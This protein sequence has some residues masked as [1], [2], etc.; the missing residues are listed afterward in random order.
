[1]KSIFERLGWLF[2]GAVCSFILTTC[3]RQGGGDSVGLAPDTLTIV[4]PG[5]T[6]LRD[7]IIYKPRPYYRDTGQARWMPV[8]T[9]AILLDYMT[10]KY[11]VDTL[12]NDTSCLAII[13]EKVWQNNLEH[14]KFRFQ[15]RRQSRVVTITPPPPSMADKISLWFGGTLGRS[16]SEF[17]FGPYVAIDNGRV[18]YGAFYDTYQKD[19]YLT[20]A[21]RLAA[22]KKK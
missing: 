9:F 22:F 16:S 5:D 11:Y 1:M 4:T 13:E 10:T 8:D 7:T 17:G 19:L 2:V 6:V 21:I 20:A 14:I 12:Q 15:N 18:M 3:L